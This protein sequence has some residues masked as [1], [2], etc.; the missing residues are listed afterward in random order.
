LARAENVPR[1]RFITVEGGEGV[2]KSSL[3][4]GLA[5]LLRARGIAVLTTREPG[6]TPSADRIRALFAVPAG[7]DPLLP[8]TEALLVSAS[9]A[10]HVGRLIEPSLA[11]GTWVICDRYADSMRVYQGALGKLPEKSIDAL[12]DIA[13]GGLAPDLTLLLDCDVGVS[14]ARLKGR[15]VGE[16]DVKRYDAEGRAVHERLRRAY[17]ELQAKEPERIKRLDASGTPKALLDAAFEVTSQRW[18]L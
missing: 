7:G 4:G 1:G 16:D 17:L 11:S 6:G 10:Q 5:E 18:A 8:T 9:R 3:V 15:G 14:L 13:T 12:I 2:G